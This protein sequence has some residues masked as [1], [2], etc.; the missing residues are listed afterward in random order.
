MPK[1]QRTFL[2]GVLVL[3]TVVALL[4]LPSCRSVVERRDPTGELFPQVTGQSLTQESFTFPDDFRGSPTLL[5]IG[6][7]QE[8]QFDIDRW[9]LGANQLELDVK[10]VEVPA[11]PGLAP[12]MASGFIDGGMRSGI[13]QE[14][15]RSVICVYGDA[16]E[17]VEFTG[18]RNPNPTRVVLLDA[19]GK[20]VFFHDRGYSVGSLRRLEETLESLD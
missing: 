7:K 18:N 9:L 19:A 14:D 12:R 17:V 8:S 13:P 1:P 5:L 3:T 11:I 20:V 6:F 4:M 10:M 15:W 2:A 16:S